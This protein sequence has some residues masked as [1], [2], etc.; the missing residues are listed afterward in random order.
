MDPTN[1]IAEK[2]SCSSECT[3]NNSSCYLKDKD[4]NA[5][6]GIGSSHK[7][8]FYMCYNKEKDE[9][10]NYPNLIIRSFQLASVSNENVTWAKDP[11]YD[12]INEPIMDSKLNSILKDSARVSPSNPDGICF[13]SSNVDNLVG[14][15][16]I[17]FNSEGK[18]LSLASSNDQKALCN[19][20]GGTFSDSSSGPSIKKCTNLQCSADDLAKNRCNCYALNDGKCVGQNIPTVNIE[21]KEDN[22]YL[23]GVFL[24]RKRDRMGYYLDYANLNSED[25]EQFSANNAVSKQGTAYGDNNFIKV[26][27]KGNPAKLYIFKTNSERYYACASFLHKASRL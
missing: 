25:I 19:L 20:V 17:A 27:Q 15:R 11:T 2:Y 5:V 3:G 23:N 1:N 12:A 8:E 24:R 14:N 7:A 9:N 10:K 26:H 21:F 13:G 18:R 16:F 6:Y 22:M 4:S